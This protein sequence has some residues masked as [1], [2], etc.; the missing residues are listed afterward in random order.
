M[1]NIQSDS[2]NQLVIGISDYYE[3]IS[4][5]FTDVVGFTKYSSSHSPLEIVELLDRLFYF[6]DILC[7]KHGLYKVKTIGDAYMAVNGLNSDNNE[8]VYDICSKTADFALDVV[9]F[10]K[11]YKPVYIYI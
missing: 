8:S 5:V 10:V 7:N 6:M 2:T 9:H 4:V 3:N 11:D 1:N